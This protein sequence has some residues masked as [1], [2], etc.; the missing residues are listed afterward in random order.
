[1]TLNEFIKMLQQREQEWGHLPI[2]V[3]KFGVH[4]SLTDCRLA[5][6][7]AETYDLKCGVH[8]GREHL[9]LLPGNY[10]LTEEEENDL[11]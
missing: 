6:F 5:R 7:P 2:F 10:Q 9:Y 4:S 8:Y 11:E 3:A 1:M